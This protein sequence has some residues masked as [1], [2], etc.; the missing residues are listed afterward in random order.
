MSP[1][2]H[3]PSLTIFFI[4][5]HQL[6]YFVIQGSFLNILSIEAKIKGVQLMTLYVDN[7][8]DDDDDDGITCG[9]PIDRQAST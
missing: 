8:D 7:D 4:F 5:D 1:I 3:D 6:L 2:N 9:T